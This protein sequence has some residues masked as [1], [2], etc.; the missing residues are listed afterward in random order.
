ML[1]RKKH[2]NVFQS[3]Y[4]VDVPEDEETGKTILTNIE[5]EDKDS[6]GDNLEVGCIPNEQV[7]YF[8]F[9]SSFGRWKIITM[10]IQNTCLIQIYYMSVS[11]RFCDG[12]YHMLTIKEIVLLY[13]A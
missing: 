6:V 4:E 2:A 10:A 9:L 12:E 7:K 1:L 11:V 5:V 3:P 8:S 13:I